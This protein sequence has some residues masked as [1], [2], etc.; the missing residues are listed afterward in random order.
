MVLGHCPLRKQ[1]RQCRES[2]SH[3]APMNVHRIGSLAKAGWRSA[4]WPRT[5]R[6]GETQGQLRAVHLKHLRSAA[7]LL[8]PDQRQRYG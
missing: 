4:V 1:E 5:A 6:I 7:E 8:T 2:P 3:A